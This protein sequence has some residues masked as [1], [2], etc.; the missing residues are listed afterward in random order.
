MFTVIFQYRWEMH[1]FIPVL[2][3]PNLYLQFFV[4]G[5]CLCS[6]PLYFACFS[7]LPFGV[8]V[9]SIGTCRWADSS[10]AKETTLGI[11]ESLPKAL[12]HLSLPVQTGFLNHI[13]KP[14]CSQGI[15]LLYILNDPWSN[16]DLCWK[17]G[18]V[19]IAA[20][21]S[22]IKGA[23]W[24]H[25]CPQVSAFRRLLALCQVARLVQSSP[26]PTSQLSPTP[27]PRRQPQ[28]HFGLIPEKITVYQIVRL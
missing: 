18:L 14:N 25:P 19:P 7:Q 21:C 23:S 15:I 12:C 24:L 20:A 17:I 10:E 13:K 27:G 3:S 26:P 1:I 11:F 16:F 9:M 6:L 8:C 28:V 4:K 2:G 5:T 22:W